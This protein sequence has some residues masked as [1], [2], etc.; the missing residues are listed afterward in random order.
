MSGE[1]LLLVAA[2][3]AWWAM[4]K[5]P[6]TQPDDPDVFDAAKAVA[7]AAG[8][9]PAV[10]LGIIYVESGWR[11]DAKVTSGSD[12][13]RGGAYGLTQMTLRTAQALDP[14]I[15]ADA[16]LDPFVNIRVAGQL[17]AENARVSTDPKDVAAMWNS[18]RVFDRAPESTRTRYVPAVLRAAKNY[19]P[20]VADVDL[21]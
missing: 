20:D 12:G 8:I 15:N 18:G 2:L 11:A 16:L 19:S 6:Q 1:V 4:K 7:T 14:S 17:L 21:V 10:F 5:A 9:D 13:E 3:V